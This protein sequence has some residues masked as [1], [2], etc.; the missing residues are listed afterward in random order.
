MGDFSLIKRKTSAYIPRNELHF[1]F[2]RKN[3]AYFTFAGY[4]NKDKTS[5][6]KRFYLKNPLAKYYGEFY[7]LYSNI[8]A[9]VSA[10]I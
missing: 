3:S 1:A 8:M 10:L 6:L 7:F 9:V 5:N 2:N 4:S